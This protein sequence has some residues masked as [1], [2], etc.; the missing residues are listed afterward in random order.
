MSLPEFN[1]RGTL[2]KGMHVC[3]SDEFFE[4]FCYG[5]N[6]IRS[7]YKEVL[8]QM[9]AFA[10]NRNASSVIIGGSFITN[11][12]DPNDL[13]CILIVPNE[14][15]C[16]FQTNEL[17]DMDGCEL[18]IIIINESRKDTIYAFLNMLSKDRYSLDV[19]MVEVILDKDKD[20]S[21]WDDYDDYYSVEA[22]LMAREAYI[23]RHII[24]GVKKK[25]ILVTVCNAEKFLMWNYE[26]APIVSSSGWI[27]APYLYRNDCDVENELQR[28]KGWI[29]LMYCTYESDLCVYADE[30]G[31]FLLGRYMVDESNYVKAHFDKVILSRTLLKSD[32]NWSAIIERQM[33]NFVIN[34]KDKSAEK[35]VSQHVLKKLKRDSFFGKAYIHGFADKK[36][37]NY[38]YDDMGELSSQ[39]FKNN[40]L[41][42]Y[43][44]EGALQKNID[45]VC[46]D[47]IQEIMSRSMDT[48]DINFK[49]ASLL[50]NTNY[51]QGARDL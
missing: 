31:T 3:K 50:N 16:N 39:D 23:N 45:N 29:S 12:P 44:M 17:L 30:M 11:K 14:E 2:D 49:T 34:L 41:P 38:T 36:I 43:H 32:F 4:R 40:V 8:E 42:L 5:N 33:V 46:R 47:N 27:F 51:K 18:D 6:T 7:N 9:F 28:F 48:A 13:D 21:T 26:I 22:L 20:K 25:K 37:L 24:R 35:N 1:L 15:C 10:V 19:G